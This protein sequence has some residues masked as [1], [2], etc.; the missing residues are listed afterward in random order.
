MPLDFWQA[1]ES[2]IFQIILEKPKIIAIK[3]LSFQIIPEKLESIKILSYCVIKLLSSGYIIFV[4][5]NS[6]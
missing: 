5:S 1:I 4:I 3:S 2:L 6:N